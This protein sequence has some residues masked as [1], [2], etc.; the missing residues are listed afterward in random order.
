MFNIY[1]TWIGV[2]L[3]SSPSAR[4][5]CYSAEIPVFGGMRSRNVAN[6]WVFC[7]WEF[8]VISSLA[9]PSQKP[10][11]LGVL[12]NLPHSTHTCTISSFLL[13]LCPHTKPAG[14][15][16]S[17]AQLVPLSVET[18]CRVIGPFLHDMHYMKMKGGRS[19]LKLSCH[20]LM[21]AFTQA[22]THQRQQTVTW[23]K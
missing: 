7:S 17:Q 13:R 20:A 5:S 19:E 21:E 12:S 2:K 3:P 16:V 9:S 11:D 23:L 22:E 14:G 1:F 15:T 6:S 4:A 18:S 8:P 10:P